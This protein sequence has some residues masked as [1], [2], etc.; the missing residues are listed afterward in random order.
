MN[1]KLIMWLWVKENYYEYKKK[2]SSC[3]EEMNATFDIYKL[4]YFSSY[5]PGSSGIP[6]AVYPLLDPIRY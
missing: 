3:I 4:R 1:K 2:G 5:N 6:A